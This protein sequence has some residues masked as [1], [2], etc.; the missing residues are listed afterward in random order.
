MSVVTRVACGMAVVTR[1]AK[2]SVVTRVAESIW[3]VHVVTRVA[4]G[5]SVVVPR[6]ECLIRDNYTCKPVAYST[7]AT[8]TKQSF[9]DLSPFVVIEGGD[10]RH[11]LP[12]W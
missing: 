3:Y 1:V 4:Y 11:P 10:Y 12:K 5:M 2:M 9:Y 7:T 6:T 8:T